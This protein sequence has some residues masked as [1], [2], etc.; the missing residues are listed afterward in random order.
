M[1][2]MVGSKGVNAKMMACRDVDMEEDILCRWIGKSNRMML[3]YMLAR[4]NL[5]TI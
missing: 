1:I 2:G 5:T 3:N 4:F